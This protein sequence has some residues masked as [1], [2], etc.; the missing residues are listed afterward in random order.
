MSNPLCNCGEICP[1]FDAY[2]YNCFGKDENGLIKPCGFMNI[3]LSEFK[4]L[5][6]HN[7]MGN[8]K[9]QLYL[10]D[11]DFCNCGLIT[12]YNDF[13]KDIY[14]ILSNFL[15]KW[16]SFKDLNNDSIKCQKA[17]FYLEH[18]IIV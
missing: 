17:T 14:I 3:T 8:C 12:I 13:N 5:I 11:T 16:N 6:T 10:M 2:G 7:K 15:E 4:K 9:C 1:N 18:S